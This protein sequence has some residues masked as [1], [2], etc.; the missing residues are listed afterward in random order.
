MVIKISK[1][2]EIIQSKNEIEV[3][4]FSHWQKFHNQFLELGRAKRARKIST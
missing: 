1:Q 4:V 2:F 3:L